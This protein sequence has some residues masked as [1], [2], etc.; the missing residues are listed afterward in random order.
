MSA[1]KTKRAPPV[2]PAA[3]QRKQLKERGWRQ[4]G[5]SLRWRHP[6]LFDEWPW[7]EALRLEFERDSGDAQVLGWLGAPE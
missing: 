6:S 4:I 3:S 1:T 2:R 5:R 7:Q